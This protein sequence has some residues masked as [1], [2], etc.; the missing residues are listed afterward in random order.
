VDAILA[1]VYFMLC[2]DY[3]SVRKLV[4]SK[5]FQGAMIS[6]QKLSHSSSVRVDGVTQLS[7]D[8]ITLHFENAR[9]SGGG[10]VKNVTKYNDFAIVH[11]KN[12]NGISS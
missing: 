2:A 12:R 4:V 11:F 1:D 10:E 3:K 6:V 8:M 9:R 7:E 5:P